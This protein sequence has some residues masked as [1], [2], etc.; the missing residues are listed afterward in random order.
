MICSECGKET[1]IWISCK[2]DVGF[3][4]EDAKFCWNCGK[5]VSNPTKEKVTLIAVKLPDGAIVFQ[6]ANNRTLFTFKHKTSE[7]V[8]VEFTFN[9]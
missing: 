8:E 9:K 5:R 7:P 2:K 1:R 3:N 4:I 6:D